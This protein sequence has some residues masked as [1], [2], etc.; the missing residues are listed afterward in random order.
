MALTC[1]M[2]M[3]DLFQAGFASCRFSHGGV[4]VPVAAGWSPVARATAVASIASAML[5][6]PTPPHS[7][8]WRRTLRISAALLAAWLAVT[9]GV[10]LFGPQLRWQFFGWHFGFWAT[11]Q[12]ALLVF[13][14]IVWLYAWA[15]DALEAE[16]GRRPVD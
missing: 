15:M 4:G 8:Y 12:G 11:A 9:L 16:E 6:L 5:P 14:A 3:K 10:G 7:P 1:S 2:S 13:C